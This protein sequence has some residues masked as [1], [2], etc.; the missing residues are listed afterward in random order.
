MKLFELFLETEEFGGLNTSWE[1][2]GIKI[3]LSDLL[4]VTKNIPITNVNPK[5]LE[6]YALN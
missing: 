5:T 3:T 2:D 4:S 1:H 6:K